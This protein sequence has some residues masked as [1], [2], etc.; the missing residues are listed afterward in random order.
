MT[1]ALPPSHQAL[2]V[3]E[4][5]AALRLSRFKVY[6]LIRTNQLPS[7]TIGRARRVPAD[8]LRTYMQ[9]Q[10]GDNN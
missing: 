3:P 4:V 7:F 1:T 2:K 5:M 9:N 6:D 8:A 10:M